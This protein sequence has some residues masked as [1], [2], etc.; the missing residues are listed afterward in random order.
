MSDQESGDQPPE[1]SPPRRPWA[2]PSLEVI[3]AA[4]A[5]ETGIGPPAD[6]ITG[7]S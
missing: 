6:G 4:D 3:R 2:A 5:E 1:A 7:I